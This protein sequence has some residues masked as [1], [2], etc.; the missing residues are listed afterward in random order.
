[1]DSER[2]A[3]D[4]QHAIE[5]VARLSN[6]LQAVEQQLAAADAQRQ[7]ATDALAAL[8]GSGAGSDALKEW[9]LL[10]GCGFLKM[11]RGTL[12]GK[13]RH[14]QQTA[15]ATAD[16]LRAE[17]RDLAAQLMQRGVSL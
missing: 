8:C 17:Q 15:E 2:G 9:L 11:D 16:S 13:L 5:Q 6:R 7:G 3:K 4:L 12:V 14:D 10:P 1:M